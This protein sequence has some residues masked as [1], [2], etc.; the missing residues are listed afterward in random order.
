MLELI[1]ELIISYSFGELVAIGSNFQ[2]TQ[3]ILAELFG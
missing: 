3:N 1:D 2:F